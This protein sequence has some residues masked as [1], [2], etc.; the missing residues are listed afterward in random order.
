MNKLN[1]KTLAGFYHYDNEGTEAQ[2]VSVVDHGILKNFLMGRSPISDF[3]VSNGHSR[4]QPGLPPVAR[5]G[6]LVVESNKSVPYEELK[7][8]LIEE[9]KRQ[10]KPYGLVFDEIAGGFA[11]TQ[12]FMPQ[13]F[14]L[15]PLRVTRVWVDGRP[16]ELLRG[17][18]LV[19]TPLASLETIMAAGDDT[20]TFNGVCGAESGWVPV[21]ASAPSLLVRTLETAREYKEQSKP[22][23]LPA[24]ALENSATQKSE[25]AKAQ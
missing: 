24:P 14:E 7:K 22:P 13:S 9:A 25:Q 10:N 15:L 8:E 3:K 23:V 1:G 17:V 6:N 12:S 21:S 20:D 2:K 11:I 19:G 16:D 18:N 4:A 5:Q